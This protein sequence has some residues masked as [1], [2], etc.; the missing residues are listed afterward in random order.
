MEKNLNH[1]NINNIFN[2]YKLYS[3]KQILEKND[4]LYFKIKILES[5]CLEKCSLD[6]DCIKNCFLKFDKL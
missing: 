6:E 5:I 3:N 1:L 4:N 2:N